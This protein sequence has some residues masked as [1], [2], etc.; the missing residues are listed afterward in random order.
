MGNTSAHS[1]LETLSVDF[2]GILQV[3]IL[4]QSR[5]QQQLGSLCLTTKTSY[6][7]YRPSSLN[8]LQ[9]KISTHLNTIPSPFDNQLLADL[10]YFLNPDEKERHNRL[11]DKIYQRIEMEGAVMPGRKW[12]LGHDTTIHAPKLPLIND[13]TPLRLILT[14]FGLNSMPS[15]TRLFGIKEPE[16]FNP[17]IVFKELDAVKEYFYALFISRTFT[18]VSISDES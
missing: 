3:S 8:T 1:L 12:G 9:V 18:N 14:N 5:L 17:Q 15:R 7:L 2:C 6:P 16:N 4:S 11:Q 10:L 13:A